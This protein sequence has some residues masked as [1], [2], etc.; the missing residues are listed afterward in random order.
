MYAIYVIYMQG[1][2]IACENIISE[3]ITFLLI[4]FFILHF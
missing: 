3:E 1:C 4:G 2:I